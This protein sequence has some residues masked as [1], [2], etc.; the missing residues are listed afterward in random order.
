MG[1]NVQLIHGRGTVFCNCSNSK[2]PD[3]YTEGHRNSQYKTPQEPRSKL[4]KLHLELLIQWLLKNRSWWAVSWHDLKQCVHLKIHYHLS[5]VALPGPVSAKKWEFPFRFPKRD[6]HFQFSSRSP[7]EPFIYWMQISS[8]FI[9]S[10]WCTALLLQACFVQGHLWLQ[11]ENWYPTW[12]NTL[13]QRGSQFLWIPK[14]ALTGS[15]IWAMLGLHD[16]WV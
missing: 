13:S 16:R 11:R 2:G 8:T 7:Y 15:T 4:K 12:R 14:P 6:W 1:W 10:F 5:S 3:H 9:V